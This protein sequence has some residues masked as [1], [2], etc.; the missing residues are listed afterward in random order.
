MEKEV[1]EEIEHCCPRCGFKWKTIEIIIVEIEPPEYD[2]E[3]D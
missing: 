3:P 2:G 1:E